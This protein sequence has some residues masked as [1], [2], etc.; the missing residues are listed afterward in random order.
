MSNNSRKNKR[1]KISDSP[2]LSIDMGA[3]LKAT[4][5]LKSAKEAENWSRNQEATANAAY[6]ERIKQ[7]KKTFTVNSPDT[8]WRRSP[9]QLTSEEKANSHFAKNKENFERAITFGGK[10]KSR[11]HKKSNKY[12]SKKMKIN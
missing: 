8:V 5:T 12:K 10:R 3:I 6:A 4:K 2:P 9:V 7:G 11:K 1:Q